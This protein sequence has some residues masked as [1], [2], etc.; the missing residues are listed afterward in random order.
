MEITRMINYYKILEVS[1]DASEEVIRVAYKAIAKKYHPDVCKDKKIIDEKMKL[2]NE[3]YET[4][5]DLEKRAVYDKWFNEEA[6]Q[7]D[8]S[9]S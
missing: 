4:L 2:I 6:P 3:A 7:P 8:I 5:I 9:F 1:S